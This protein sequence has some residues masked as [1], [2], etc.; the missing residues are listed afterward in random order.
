MSYYDEE[1]E[2]KKDALNIINARKNEKDKNRFK[3][4]SGATKFKL[5]K[6]NEK[7]TD[8]N[9]KKSEMLKNEKS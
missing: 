7:N 2:R 6:R 8:Y 1:A 9:K 4:Q 5:W 3:T